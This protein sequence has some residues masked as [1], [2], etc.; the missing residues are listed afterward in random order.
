MIQQRTKSM[1]NTNSQQKSFTRAESK[2]HSNKKVLSEQSPNGTLT[3]K[4]FQ[5]RVQ[6]ALQQKSFTKSDFLTRSMKSTVKSILRGHLWDKKS[7]LLIQVTVYYIIEWS[8]E[9]VL[10]V[11][12][13]D[14]S[15]LKDLFKHSKQ[16]VTSHTLIKALVYGV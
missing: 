14:N 6:M 15:T 8:H 3:K 7:G 9:Q 2:W 10:S 5:S 12:L 16:R 4:F 11:V 1:V 13:T